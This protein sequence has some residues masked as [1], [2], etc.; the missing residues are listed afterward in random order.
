M[1]R[2]LFLVSVVAVLFI[3][4]SCAAGVPFSEV[5]SSLPQIPEGM[6]RIYLYRTSIVGITVQPMVNVDR[7]P[8]KKAVPKGFFFIDVMPGVHVISCPN[9]TTREEKFITKADTYCFVRID[10]NMG[11]FDGRVKPVVV[12]KEKGEKQIRK[13]KFMG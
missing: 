11:A 5:Q 9:E 2:I 4:T 10:M 3:M 8:I 6:S 13:C 1:L 7:L 12:S